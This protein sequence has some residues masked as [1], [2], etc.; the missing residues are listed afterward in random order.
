MCGIAGMYNPRGLDPD[1]RLIRAMSAAI[2]HRGP[3]AEGFHVD[4][5]AHLAARRLSIIDLAGGD[6]PIYTPDRR[7]CIVYNGE[8]YNYRLLRRELA[9]G[10]YPFQTQTDTE[11]V[12]AAYAAWGPRCLERFKGMFAFGI[13]ESAKRTLFLAR[14]RFGI[15][16]LYLTGLP[17]GTLLFASEIKALL[18]HPRAA[19]ALYPGA[20]RNLLTYGFNL[21]PHTFFDSIKQLLPGHHLTVSPE[22][23]RDG[24]WWD[25][26]LEAPALTESDED[27]AL[28]LR[29]RFEQSVAESLAAD[30]PVA[31][32]LSGGIDSSAVTG[33][34]C[35]A[36]SGPVTT[37]TITFDDAGYDESAFSRL[38]SA[39]FRTR[40][41]EFKCAVSADDIR[42]LV[43][44]L[45]NPLVSLLNLPLYLL[46]RTTRD[47]GI[48]VVLTGD[49][50]DEVLGGYDYFKLLKIMAFIDKRPSPFRTS[51]LRRL[52][53]HLQNAEDARAQ[54]VFLTNARERFPVRHPAMPYQFHAFQM[55]EQLLAADFNRRLQ[56]RP[57]D[58]PF[59][60][61]PE[62]AAHRTLLDQALYLETKMRLLNLTLP[63][64]DT[65]SMAH[66]VEARPLFLDHELVNLLFRIP[67]ASKMRGLSEKNIL[68]QSMRGRIPEA[69]CQRVKQPL[70]PPGRWFLD[71]AGPMLHDLLSHDRIREAGCFNP[72]FVDFVL[73]E[74][75][76][77]SRIDYSGL[78]V[79]IF[80]VQLWHDIFIARR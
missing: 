27:I 28:M 30:V 1:P 24:A 52:Y 42:N 25:I 16:P 11:V 64:S 73:A 66:S 19:R 35:R 62:R 20:V 13:W 2:A 80:F 78:I 70:Q 38:A 4:A 22:A 9:A 76:A 10:G 69:I 36:S 60:F 34:Y 31:S 6:Q 12:L 71:A 29:E 18:Q 48:K 67:A 63:L 57:P 55:H 47:Q 54:H 72:G 74:H 75:A 5:V 26:D 61:D 37:V 79:T 17:D 7:M 49:G 77:G 43:Y 68:K 44:Y 53:P 14:D 21:A 32:Y 50:S 40:N 3:D 15:K 46:S 58:S 45:E 65:M 51:L 56:E 23:V 41:I 33:A 8:L 39:F 59:F